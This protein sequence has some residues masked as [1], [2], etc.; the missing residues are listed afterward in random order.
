VKRWLVAFTVFSLVLLAI[1]PACGGGGDDGTS[2]PTKVVTATPTQTTTSSATP[3][4]IP[5]SK[6]STPS[7]TSG[8]PVKIGGITSWS[9]AA[10]MSGLNFADPAIK[11]VEWQVKQQGGI[12]GGR[13]VKVVKYDNRASVADA[14]AGAQKMMI[15]DKISAMT[16]GGVSGAESAAMS[17]FAE[18]NH[19]LYVLF[20]A[21]EVKDPKYTL[22]ATVGYDELIGRVSELA[23]KVLHP[24]KVAMLTVDFADG[25]QR[26][27]LLRSMLEV[28]GIQI[29]YEQYVPIDTTDMSPY[30][31]QIRSKNPDMFYCDSGTSEFFLNTMKAFQDQGGWGAMKV[32]ALAQ[33][34]QAKTR[35]GAQGVYVSTLWVPGMELPGAKKFEQ[36]Y[37]TLNNN[38]IPDT[39]LVYYYNGLWT[40][41]K[42]IELAGTDT[43]LEKIANMA[44]FSG[45]LEWDTPMGHAHYTA[46][47]GGY[48]QLKATMTQ[49]VDKKLV[50]V[51]IPE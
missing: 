1:L 32:V 25:R 3:S 20:G 8:S 17:E 23:T 46:E 50:V 9:G 6:T 12:L 41:I 14:V 43:D 31:T 16:F 13:E 39:N 44:R 5:T 51:P 19:I 36:D 11:L 7:P 48:P 35:S 18:E 49:I 28:A 27:P 42:A 24:K 47:S 33:A 40:C 38:K 22:S 21:Q 26:L 45:Q 34:E 2:T 4:A 30:V 29:V 37:A 10:A 15:N